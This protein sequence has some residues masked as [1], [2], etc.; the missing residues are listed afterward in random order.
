MIENELEH[1]KK[2]E[3]IEFGVN[4]RLIFQVVYFGW[5]LDYYFMLFLVISKV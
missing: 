3:K 4:R 1:A 5:L 2:T